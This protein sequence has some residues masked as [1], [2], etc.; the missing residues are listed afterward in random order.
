MR[1]CVNRE[2][3]RDINI[4]NKSKRIRYNIEMIRRKKIDR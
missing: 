1:V 3:E 4:K 2:R